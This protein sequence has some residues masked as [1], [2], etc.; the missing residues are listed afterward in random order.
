MQSEGSAPGALRIVPLSGI[1]EVEPGSDLATLL[2]AAA[3][4]AG[5]RLTNGVLVLCQKIV[6]KAEGRMVDFANVEPGEEARR[7]A[8]EDE[9]DPRHVEVILRESARIVR[10]GHGVLICETHHGFVCANAGVDLSNSPG[11]EIAILLPE[12]CDASAV[13]LRDALCQGEERRLGVVI[14]DTFGRPWREGLVDYAIGSAGLA[15]ISDL[16]GRADLSGRELQVTATATVDQLAA[17]AGILMVKDAGIPA[18][19][20]EGL[21]PEGDGG[22]REI[23]RDP[24]TDLFR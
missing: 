19:W 15:P 23:L 9:R 18:V 13:R 21:L 17:A 11:P 10:R 20:I 16:R 3:E 8:A 7:I 6:S 2:C 22:V 1:P 4:R 5:V 24:A 12:D 14:T